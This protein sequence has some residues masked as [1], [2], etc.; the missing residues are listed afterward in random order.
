MHKYFISVALVAMIAGP[1]VLADDDQKTTGENC[2]CV[3]NGVNFF[4]ALG[5][6]ALSDYRQKENIISL[7]DTSEKLLKI[8]GYKFNYVGD[9]AKKV[10]IGVM[11]QE[12]QKEFPEAIHVAETGDLY[13]NYQSLVPALVDAV[14]KLSTQVKELNADINRMKSM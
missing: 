9:P 8:H 6:C 1:S 12:V 7:G 13:V 10:H 2:N 14:N 11:A 4:D 5:G 3:C